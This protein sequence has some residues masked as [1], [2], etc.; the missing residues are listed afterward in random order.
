MNPLIDRVAQNAGITKKLARQ[1]IEEVFAGIV[2]CANMD[3]KITIREFGRFEIRQRKARINRTPIQG[4]PRN[5]P[6]RRTLT[7]H[8]SPTLVESI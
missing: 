2:H 7:F 8:C 6:A 5:I 3:G 1:V 4:D